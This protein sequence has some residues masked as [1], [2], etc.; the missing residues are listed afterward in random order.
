MYSRSVK[1]ISRGEKDS[2]VTRGIKTCFSN[3]DIAYFLGL[4][5]YISTMRFTA[6]GISRESSGF[7]VRLGRG[8]KVLTYRLASQIYEA[9]DAK[10]KYSEILELFNIHEEILDYSLTNMDE[11]K[12]EIINGLKILCNDKNVS[13]PYV[14]KRIRERL[15]K[16]G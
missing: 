7:N 14:T 8:K 12:D 13:K 6:K 2:A 9:V 3:T 5:E 1:T 10:F 4:P 16:E 11:I 15:E